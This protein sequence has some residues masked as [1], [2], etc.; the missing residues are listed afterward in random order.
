MA[1]SCF[2]A[3][4]RPSRPKPTFPKSSKSWSAKRWPSLSMLKSGREIWGRVAV[5][6]VPKRKAASHDFGK[7][8]SPCVIALV[9]LLFVQV[10]Y[11][12]I[13]VNLGPLP[14]PT[15]HDGGGEGLVGLGGK[16]INQ[17][18]IRDQDVLPRHHFRLLRARRIKKWSLSHV[19]FRDESLISLIREGPCL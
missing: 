10:R 12:S 6:M 13:I 3:G 17:P 14:P 18:A 19:Q 16:S 11:S 7:D 2:P 5:L 8:N 1:A 9:A 15:C 4:S